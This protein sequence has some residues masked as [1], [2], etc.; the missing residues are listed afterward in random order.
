MAEII[1]YNAALITMDDCTT[2]TAIALGGGRILAVGNDAPVRALATD[3]TRVI[4]AQGRTVMPGLNESHVHIF[5][6]SVGL[7][8]LSLFEQHGFEH[9]AGLIRSYGRD[10][11]DLPILVCLGAD[12]TIFGEATP[13]RHQLDAIMADRPLALMSPDFHTVWANTMALEAAGLLHGADLPPG[14]EI[15]MGRDGLAHGELR[16]GAAFGP[17]FDLT[18]TKGRD[19]LGLTTG[20]DPAESPS[21]DDLETDRETMFLGLRHMASFGITSFQNMDGNRYTLE[22]LAE[23][24]AEGRLLCRGRVPGR[25]VA[26][27][28]DTAVAYSVAL[29]RDFNSDTLSAGAIKFFADGVLDSHTAIMSEDYADRPGWRGEALYDPEVFN[30]LCTRAD[31]AGLQIAVH[32]IGDGASGMTLD[33]LA[34]ARTV[35]GARDSRHRIEHLEVV[36]E[37]DFERLKTLDVIPSMQPTHPPGQC[38]LPMEPTV[39]RIGEANFARAYAWRRMRD[40]GLPLILSTDWPVSSVDP[41]ASIHAAMTRMPW[42]KSQP[43]NRLTLHEALEGYT[44]NAAFAE[45]KED[46]KGRLCQGYLA[47][48]ILLDRDLTETTPEDIADVKCLLTLCGGKVTHDAL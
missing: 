27:D 7:T 42:H 17:I 6:G 12:Y 19:R 30:D 3:E 43:D 4:D 41:W 31:A 22:R 11:P 24:E 21:P 39:S 9:V 44:T 37:E 32:A 8:Q 40:L 16:E 46:R 25:H 23:L 29:A 18:P 28:L 20:L 14:H 15:V 10:N 26:G 2:G 5:S 38:G 47:D 1:L 45:F 48:V 34:A 35:N 33:A 36:R 13:T